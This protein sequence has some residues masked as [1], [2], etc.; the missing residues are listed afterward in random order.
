MVCIF[1][2]L[3]FSEKPFFNVKLKFRMKVCITTL[4]RKLPVQNNFVLLDRAEHNLIKPV[5][6]AN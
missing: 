1:Q 4:I 2:R 3:L 6:L 5:H